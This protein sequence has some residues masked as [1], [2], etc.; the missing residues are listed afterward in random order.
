MQKHLQESVGL[1]P[2]TS[3]L[4]LSSF[5]I[6]E[7]TIAP[8]L[9]MKIDVPAHWE[10]KAHSFSSMEFKPPDEAL[11]MG[12]EPLP[13][14][15]LPMYMPLENG[16]V[17]RQGAKDECG[18]AVSLSCEKATCNHITP[19]STVFVSSLLEM[20]PRNIFLRPQASVRQ[21]VKLNGPRETEAGYALRPRRVFRT[22]PTTFLAWQNTQRGFG[23]AVRSRGEEGFCLSDVCVESADRKQVEPIF[24]FGDPIVAIDDGSAF[25]NVWNVAHPTIPPLVERAESV[26]S[27]SDSETDEDNDDKLTSGLPLLSWKHALELFEDKIDDE[28]AELYEAGEMLGRERGV[29]SFERYRHLIRQER[30]Y[31]S[32]RQELVERLPQLL[33]VISTQ[34]GHLD[35][36]LLVHNSEEDRDIPIKNK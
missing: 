1:A 17:L 3:Q 19:K 30:A 35:H 25:Q 32:Y 31:N 11:S 13:I 20:L 23:F 2:E 24:S 16:R 7:E 8:R 9:R 12:H 33:K 10:L 4:Y 34:I 14:P 18:M 28:V 36:A 29:Y 22:L 5:P 27:L 6:V 15:A 21:F 26:P